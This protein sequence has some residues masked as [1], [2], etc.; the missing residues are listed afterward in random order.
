MQYPLWST[1]VTVPLFTLEPRPECQMADHFNYLPA[2]DLL[3]KLTYSNQLQSHNIL[4]LYRIRTRSSVLLVQAV[5]FASFRGLWR[6]QLQTPAYNNCCWDRGVKAELL[7]RGTIPWDISVNVTK[8][9]SVAP[10]LAAVTS[11]VRIWG[12]NFA[13]VKNLQTRP[14]ELELQISPYILSPFNFYAV[15]LAFSGQCFWER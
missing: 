9:P 11:R 6:A 12:F 1:D 14:R 10:T 7:W 13:L 4:L 2:I 3:N 15:N 8:H 5:S